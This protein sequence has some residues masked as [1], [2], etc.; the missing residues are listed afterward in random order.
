MTE[1]VEKP[2]DEVD[3]FEQY[4]Q[5]NIVPLVDAENKIKDKYRGQFWGY[6]FSVLFLMS[7]NILIVLFNAQMK[8]T[9][10]SWEQL[11][12]INCLAFSLIFLPIYKYNHL[13]KNDIFDAFLQ[14]YGNWQHLRNSEV[15]LVHSPIIPKHEEV[16]ALHNVIGRFDDV[17]IEMRDTYYAIKSKTVSKGVIL[18]ATFPEKFTGTLLMFE[19][20]G[21]YRKNK[22]PQYEC[23]N[24]R[25]NIPT[26]NY[27][28]IFASDSEICDKMV[29]NLFLEYLL[30]LKD[31][32]DARH[33][34][35]QLQDNY[36]RVYMEGSQLY[37][38]N[39][40]FWGKKVDEK[41]FLQ[42]HHEFE[43]AYLFVQTVKSLMERK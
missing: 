17:S 15:K 13:P 32:F 20:G 31:I 30:N 11:F 14:F 40:K 24:D 4:F 21:F 22:F 19:R 10:I 35:V 28:N 1:F 7:I 25:I 9:P 39:Y 41:H 37:I 43:N 38:N 33:V 36:M 42:M 12:L 5:E 6:L 23:F 29:H 3:P 34:Y 27:F 26:A 18:Y 16:K 8:H 2:N